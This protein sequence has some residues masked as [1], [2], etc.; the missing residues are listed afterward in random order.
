M[1]NR[2]IA[3]VTFVPSVITTLNK[4]YALQHT[5]NKIGLITQFIMSA[6]VKLSYGGVIFNLQF[7]RLKQKNKLLLVQ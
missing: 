7:I 4:I 2:I 6:T 3:S 1:N 5:L